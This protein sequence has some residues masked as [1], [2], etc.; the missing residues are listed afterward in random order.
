MRSSHTER[1]CADGSDDSTPQSARRKVG[2]MSIESRLEAERAE[3]LAMIRQLV[4]GFSWAV[5]SGDTYTCPWCRNY[6]PYLE[7][8]DHFSECELIKARAF[9]NSAERLGA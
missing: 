8:E 9:L 1:L 3:G 6:W 4:T 7:A 5:E 2:S